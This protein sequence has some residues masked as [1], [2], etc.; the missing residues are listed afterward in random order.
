MAAQDY[1][2]VVQQLYVS[3][4]GR[5]ADYYG[6]QDFAAQLEALGAP[7]T[8][9]A[10]NVA[11]QSPDASAGLKALVSGFDSS[12][13][14]IALY[15]SDTS[16]IG[17]SKF[18]AAIYQNVL[19]REPDVSGLDFWVKAITS[20]T[21]S[22]A[23]AAA[24]ISAAAVANP[25][26]PDSA[27]VQ[28]K[29]N[30][31]TNFT[32]AIDTAAEINGFS[33][34]A[35]AASA[36]DLLAAVDSTTNVEAYQ[37]TVEAS[38]EAIVVAS[39]PTTTAA[40]TQGLDNLTGGAGNDTFNATE[41]VVGGVAQATLTLG[42][43]INGGSGNDTL[44][45]TQT[46]ALGALSN[47]T[48]AN[49]ENVNVTVANTV[50]IDTT[51]W[52]GVTALN[53]N[54]VG[55]TTGT[56]IVAA[57]TTNVT[58]NNSGTGN[59]VVA[60]GLA[61]TVTTAAGVT[62]S[63]ATGAITTTSSAQAGNAILVNGGT[64]VAVTAEGQTTGTITVGST[65]APTGAVTV[66]AAVGYADGVLAAG[67]ISVKGGT[68]VEVNATGVTA[69]AAT[70][71]ATDTSNFTV[72][73]GSVTVTGGD[74]TTDVTVNQANAVTKVDATG[75]AGADA[76]GK[77][78]IVNGQVVIAD[79]NVAS[80]TA[81][82]TIATVT[83]NS[84]GASSTVA[85]SALTTLNL[86]GTGVDL[87]VTDGSLTTAA[88]TEQAVNVNGLT[89][90]GAVTLDAHITTLN[91]NAATK[92]STIAS[93]AASGAATLNIGGDAAVTL[94]S[95]TLAGAANT[96]TVTNTAGVTLGAA[97]ATNTTFTGGDG[98][99][100]IKLTGG[101]TKAITLGAGDDTVTYA[102]VGT[103]GSV[104]A[105][106]GTDT[107]IITGAAAV[108]ASASS[109][110]N[111]K[112]TGFEVLELSSGDVGTINL[113]GVN[114]ISSVRAA[115][116]EVNLE[117]LVSNG[118]FTLTG[119]SV[120][121]TVNVAAA[122]FNPA[123]VL[124]IGLASTTA[125]TG[126]S[127]VAAG[128]ETINISAADAAAAGSS[129]VV[130][131]L[132]LE[133]VAA[134]SVVVTG[135]NGV[136]LTNT[137]NVAITSF[138]ASGVVANGTATADTA[139]NLAVTFVSENTTASAAV[140]ITGGAGND[141]LT[142]SVAIDTINGGAGNDTIGGLAGADVLNGGEGN[143]TITGGAGIDTL[144]GGEG[145]DI[146]VF[147]AG[148]AGI[149]GTERVTDFSI[150]LGGDKLDLSTT[151][152]VADVT[153]SNITS[154]INGAVDLTATVKNGIITLGGAD[155]SLVDTIGELKLVFEALEAAGAA[156]TAAIVWGGNTYVITDTVG[157]AANDI[158]Q[159][160][161]VTG[162][163]SLSTTDAAN[164]IWIS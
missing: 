93:L 38:L 55:G 151:T 74:A 135:N 26:G 110:F 128:V 152:L 82:G 63:G 46:A 69:A 49:V 97:L 20:G 22:R 29:V 68:T 126:G 145:A 149:T 33:G 141:T 9:A 133:A 158:I 162:A 115:G 2:A 122:A 92:E 10:L 39:I 83:I 73:L 153:A 54:S 8:F 142:G 77:I 18:V 64:T 146:F 30:V 101:F 118:T 140:S 138:D 150:A 100:S 163:T 36:R 50:Q 89:T 160:V 13:E 19:N 148:D 164:S 132:T 31:A 107:I 40:L 42:D 98:A 57:A 67:N 24:S 37:A 16:T 139:A 111:S 76:N 7:K 14:A 96:I 85:S 134:T 106:E 11:I 121:A 161:G 113:L 103:G 91:L 94:T 65:A 120:D 75:T 59:V 52:T 108:T 143:D 34:D 116:G 45:I 131:E 62:L 123:D 71:A 61:Q 4:F 21:L 99:D 3:Y 159:L 102:A 129:A 136:N 27:T 87:T 144:T 156:D 6:L 17:T 124:N 95:H 32:A 157:G 51:A 147:A 1:Y 137:G 79:K 43:K 112:F 35:A 88:V 12:P 90:T 155:A 84:F 117:G 25:T 80:A 78:G 119:N 56:G 41:V 125:L 114:N 5:P 130:H 47:V 127:V 23:N 86:S 104:A 15:G 60:G 58:A 154:A 66:D 28:N 105:G 72:T 109:A 81:A 44:N 53:V 48:V 70:A